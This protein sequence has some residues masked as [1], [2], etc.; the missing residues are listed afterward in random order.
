MARRSQR[1][2][3]RSAD[4]EVSRRAF[5]GAGT[6]ALVGGTAGLGVLGNPAFAEQLKKTDKRVILLFLSGGAS[7]FET[8]D[9]K[10]GRPTGG[11]FLTIPTS[12]PGVRISELMPRMAQEIHQHTAII[13]SISTTNTG[14]DGRGV[15]QLL[16]GERNDTGNLDVPSLGSMLARELSNPGSPLPENIAFYSAYV[17]L[18]LNQHPQPPVPRGDSDSCIA[19]QSGRPATTCTAHAAQSAIPCRPA[20]RHHSGQLRRGVRQSEEPERE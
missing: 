3:C 19:D 2:L 1:T 8:W 10:P 11:P 6:G 16:S 13:R 9:P 17:G 12:I 15:R 14:H 5:L 7:Q 4:H 20:A 18:T